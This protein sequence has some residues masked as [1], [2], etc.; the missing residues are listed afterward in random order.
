M[1]R[2]GDG[3][4]RNGLAGHNAIAVLQQA[5]DLD[6]LL[7][8]AQQLQ[9]QLTRVLHGSTVEA[10]RPSTQATLTPRE[11]QVLELL[12]VGLADKEIAASLS[13][14]IRTVRTHLEHTRAKLALR[15]RRALGAWYWRQARPTAR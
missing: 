12:A 3:P 4:A 2:I 8:L 15:S 9:F 10:A 11:W 14:S 1:E 7:V 6:S 5:S 13:I